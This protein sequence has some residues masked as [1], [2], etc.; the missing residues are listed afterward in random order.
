MDALL[1]NHYPDVLGAVFYGALIVFAILEFV[2]PWRSA[3][4]PLLTRWS[5]NFG[6]GILQVLL[7]R[8]LVPISLLKLAMAAEARDFG[9]FHLVELPSLLAIV[10]GVV[11]LDLVKYGEH[12]LFHMVPVLWRAHVVHH[13]DLEVDFTTGFRHHPIEVIFIAIPSAA[14]VIAFGITPAAVAAY[15]VLSAGS[16]VFTHTNIR[17]PASVDRW[18]RWVTVTPEAHVVHHSS[19][20]VET[21]SN[22]GQL[23]LWWDRLFGTY[24]AAPQHGVAMMQIGVEH[25]RESNDLRLDRAL[26]QPFRV[27]VDA[28]DQQPAPDRA[29]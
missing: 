9:L 6:L 18:L 3:R 2:R 21:D 14:A 17:L 5:T 25:F 12:R 19:H 29:A 26:V 10:V 22:F 28:A 7:A 8:V 24:R 16:A 4:Y 1:L 13:S 20:R 27:P 11:L 15:V 23:F